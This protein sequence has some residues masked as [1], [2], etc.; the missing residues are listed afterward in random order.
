MVGLREKPSLGVK[1]RW[2]VA[3]GRLNDLVDAMTRYRRGQYIIPPEWFEEAGE[4][5]RWLEARK[6][7]NGAISNG[8]SL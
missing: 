6:Q 5:A 4:I 2:L 3:E 7:P 1:P 8:G